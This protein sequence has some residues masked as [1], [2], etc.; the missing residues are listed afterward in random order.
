MGTGQL[1][2][3]LD[4]IAANWTA[5]DAASGGSTETGA[6]VKANGYGLGAGRVARAL[7]HAG[8]RR[9]FVAHAEEG[10]AIRNA[11]GRGPEIYV[12]SGHMRGDTDMLND[13][14]LIPMINSI[15]QL[16]RHFEALPDA[17]FGI[18][19]DTGMNRLG[20]E[21]GEW[22]AVRDVAVPRKPRLIMSHLASADEP[23]SPQNKAQVAL[24]RELTAGCGIPRSLAATGGILL[25]PEYHFELT[26]PGI[27]LY[28]GRPFTDARPV[29]QLD[30]PV[31]QTGVVLKGEAVGYNATWEAEADTPTA[32]VLGG[33]ADGILRALT[34]T[35]SLWSD[36][37][38][39]PILGRVSMD[40]I[41]VD[42]SGLEREPRELSLLCP[43]QG[44][45][46]VADAGKTIGYEI[47]TSLGPRYA[48][49]YSGRAG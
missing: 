23:A 48:R 30:L 5:L 12:F 1:T 28:G 18:Q 34:N 24:F 44:V 6:V 3:D 15:D 40:A 10:G 22:A 7:A 36:G 46:A 35:G 20:M 42:I 16:T 17:P 25:G 49:R 32:T 43:E 37:I 11:L 9:F 39:C 2:I 31:V 29:V 38:E 47:L 19:L 14:D 33:Y 27:G 8:A 45:D 21:P 13:L 41:T 26:R 4:A